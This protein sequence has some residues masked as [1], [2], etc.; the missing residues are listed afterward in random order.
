MQLGNWSEKGE[1]YFQSVGPRLHVVYLINLQPLITNFSKY[2]PDCWCSGWKLKVTLVKCSVWYFRAIYWSPYVDQWVLIN[3]E[4]DWKAMITKRRRIVTTSRPNRQS[5]SCKEWITL[6]IH[7][8]KS[9]IQLL[10]LYLDHNC[11]NYSWITRSLKCGEKSQPP[12]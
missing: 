9:I 12:D 6:L 11:T 2:I 1:W 5:Y 10:F 8:N 3:C 7:W 4:N